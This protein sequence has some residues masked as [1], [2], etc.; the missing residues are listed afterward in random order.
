[1]ILLVNLIRV[2]DLKIL[3]PTQICEEEARFGRFLVVTEMIA[4][5]IDIHVSL[6]H[7]IY[8]DPSDHY[9]LNLKAPQ[10]LERL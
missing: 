2:I 9:F 6:F 10:N 5:A 1:M 3:G 7:K 8:F 4:L